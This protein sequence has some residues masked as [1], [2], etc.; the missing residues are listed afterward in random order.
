MRNSRSELP[1]LLADLRLRDDSGVPLHR[2]LEDALRGLIQVGQL[3]PGSSLPGEI[4]LAQWLGVSRH[5]VRH[6]LGALVTEGLLR[7]QRGAGTTVV[8]PRL[9]APIERPLDGFYAF[10]WE[11]QARGAE[12]HSQ[13]LRR[14]T[15]PA[16]GQ[17]AAELG[18]PP[19]TAIELIERLRMANGEPLVLE[20]SY[21]PLD[22][23]AY[24]DAATLEQGAIYDAWEQHGG[25]IT[26]AHETIRPV[27][28]ERRAARLLGVPARS[29]A[30]AV[31]RVTWM[32]ER[33]VEFQQSLVRGDRY[34]YTVDL[35][36]TSAP[37]LPP[38]LASAPTSV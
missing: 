21:V 35:R 13:V 23:A 11:A 7:R 34:L 25:R 36:R 27:T 18:V 37:M 30:F 6:A 26:H 2:Q 38:A 4:G 9:N 29:P 19:G 16:A 31:D 8:E 5:T 17:V 1:A 20:L 24:L 3:R 32:G 33:P 28:L 10:A 22:M 14:A 12:H 15:E